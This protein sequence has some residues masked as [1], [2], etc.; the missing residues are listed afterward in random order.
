MLIT[1]SKQQTICLGGPFTHDYTSTRGVYLLTNEN[2]FLFLTK[3]MICFFKNINMMKTWENF[4]VFGLRFST[5]TQQTRT[6]FNGARK[7]FNVVRSRKCCP[8]NFEH[9]KH[10]PFSKPRLRLWI[11]LQALSS[12]L[13]PY[14]HCKYRQHATAIY[15]Y[16]ALQVFFMGNHLVFGASLR[17]GVLSVLCSYLRLDMLDNFI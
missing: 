10:R 3:V 11:R 16:Y 4:S 14:V 2:K 13:K 6:T 17:K 7:E 9:E 12:R 5:F 15:F 8:W 1:P